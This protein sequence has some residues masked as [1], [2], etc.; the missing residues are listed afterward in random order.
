MQATVLD[1]L[2][3]DFY[4]FG[5]RIQHWMPVFGIVLAILLLFVWL[6]DRRF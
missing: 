1:W 5:L 4:V 2:V 6:D 3:A